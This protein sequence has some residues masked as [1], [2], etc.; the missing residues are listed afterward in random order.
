[1]TDPMKKARSR[2]TRLIWRPISL[3]LAINRRTTLTF[4]LWLR[5]PVRANV[6]RSPYSTIQTVA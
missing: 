2:K 5:S 4:D 3:I 6:E 1:M